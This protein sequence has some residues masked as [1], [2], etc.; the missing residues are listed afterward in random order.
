MRE[1]KIFH[2]ANLILA[3]IRP[4]KE[5]LCDDARLPY[6][7]ILRAWGRSDLEKQDLW[8]A[9]RPQWSPR[10]ATL[11]CRVAAERL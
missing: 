9:G 8:E 7:V 6:S 2:N 1:Y 11:R 5:T 10:V 4:K 3:I